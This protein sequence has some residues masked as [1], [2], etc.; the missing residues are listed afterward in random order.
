MALKKYKLGT[1]IEQSEDRNKELKFSKDAVV[2]LSTQKLIIKTKADLTGVNVASYKLFKPKHFAYVPDTSRRADKVSM[3][4]NT[5][6]DTFL[7]SSISTIFYVSREDILLSDYLFMYFNR[8]EFDRYAR[9]NSW[10]SARETFDWSEMC[11]I[12]IELPSIEVQQKY[13]NVYK[14]MVANQKAYEKGLDDLK[15]VCDAYIEDLRRKYPCEEIGNY[16][17]EINIKN[18]DEK[19]KYAIGVSVNGIFDSV[20]TANKESTKG[21]KI[22]N[23][24]NLLWA[25][26][27]TC[28]IGIGAVDVYKG[29]KTAIC[30]PTCCIIKTNEPLNVDYLLM[31][32]KRNEFLRYA[33]FYGSGVVEKFGI[34]LMNEVKIPIP[35]IS[36]Q[37]AI[38]NIFTV[39]KKRK[40]INES[41]KT[42]IKNLC[43]ILIAGAI[44][45]AKEE[46]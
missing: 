34:E 39:Y 43:P 22:V 28:G 25:T 11:D 7:V 36:I 40:E 12:D 33:Q 5:T 20:R 26:Q 10:G 23:Y 46:V 30:A 14:A 44:K 18:S 15:L 29:D 6:E 4:Y 9:F 13:V 38:V 45:E 8:P 42:Q 21:C 17:E 31:W 16:I 41:L 1:L 19:I 24:N 35:D 3:G 37:N 32:L 27:T 2:G